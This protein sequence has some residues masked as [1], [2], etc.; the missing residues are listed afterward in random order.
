MVF[1]FIEVLN[2]MPPP[3]RETPQGEERN[4]GFHCSR[5]I[6]RTGHRFPMNDLDILGLV[7][8]Y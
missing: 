6:P 1:G 5:F 2:S 4:S 7:N 3:P 8:I